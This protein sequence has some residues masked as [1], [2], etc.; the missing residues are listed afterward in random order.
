MPS[1]THTDWHKLHDLPAYAHNTTPP[2][3][4]PS[5]AWFNL[6]ANGKAA[7]RP[8]AEGAHQAGPHLF[9]GPPSA[10]WETPSNPTGAWLAP[11]SRS[12]TL[13]H[14]AYCSS[15]DIAAKGERGCSAAA[16]EASRKGNF[17]LVRARGQR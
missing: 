9:L 1:H 17:A 8:D 2:A 14:Y 13:L 4:V 12:T 11:V 15:D 10:R 16:A 6:Y 3:L 5:Q 7:V